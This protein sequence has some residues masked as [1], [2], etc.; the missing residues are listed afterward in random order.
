LLL[1]SQLEMFQE[2]AQPR[3]Q[4]EEYCPFGHLTHTRL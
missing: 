2:T 1:N 4:S 3:I